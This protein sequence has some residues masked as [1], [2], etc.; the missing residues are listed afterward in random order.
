MA[1]PSD[2]VIIGD[3]PP[4]LNDASFK[5][6]FEAY[7]TL[8]WFKLSP[9]LANGKKEALVELASTD[10]AKWLVENLHGNVPLGLESEVTV[11]Y[12]PA[13]PVGGAPKGPLAGKGV[14]A[15]NRPGPYS[16]GPP[17]VGMMGGSATGGMM[18]GCPVGLSGKGGVQVVQKLG[19]G[20]NAGNS[21]IGDV[22]QAL[23]RHKVLPG[24]TWRNDEK[25]V[26]VSGLP[27]D[28]TDTDVL[29]IFATFGAIAPGGVRVVLN[30]DGT[31]KGSGM[32]NFLD[33]ESAKQAVE[34]LNNCQL[35]DGIN[36]LRLRLYH[37]AN[38][39]SKGAGKGAVK[40]QAAG[41]APGAA[42]PAPKKA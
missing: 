14:A 9:P 27:F 35:P 36:Y 23:I 16:G 2:H 31:A 15:M 11:K 6:N 24:G 3:L 1:Q 30:E 34:V 39:N 42:G 37:G 4:E 5:H 19:T 29:K 21:T 20:A 13:R 10:E 25:T 18:G 7:G 38:Y 32:I 28:T 17:L 8:K 41:P 33:I 12:K 26:T 40:S 22:W